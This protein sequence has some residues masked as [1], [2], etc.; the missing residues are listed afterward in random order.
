MLKIQGME[1]KNLLSSFCNFYYQKFL[2]QQNFQV[3]N[4]FET[5][6]YVLCS[7]WWGNFNGE[8]VPC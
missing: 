4:F 3:V 1:Q 8:N 5:V 6:I 7:G 2:S